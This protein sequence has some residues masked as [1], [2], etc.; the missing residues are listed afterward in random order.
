MKKIISII[1][2]LALCVTLTACNTAGENESVVVTKRNLENYRKSDVLI[3]F[4]SLTETFEDLEAE[5]ELIVIGEFINNSTT[6][7]LL[8]S[9]GF[10][11]KGT[12][13][14]Y[15]S[16][17]MRITKVLAGDARVGDVIN[18]LQDE[19]YSDECFHTAS[20]LTPMQ[21]G[22]EW[23]F[24][25]KHAT[26]ERYGDGYWCVSDNKGRYPTKNSGSNEAVCFSDYPALGVYEESDFQEELYNQLL[27]KYGEF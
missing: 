20:N 26:D 9:R 3:D 2:A 25:L 27:E 6:C 19:W 4:I 11:I 23:V 16:C 22:D 15:S 13:G 5:S 10:E 21:M 1:S 14:G 7:Y 12:Y 24:C 8:D 17:P 18:V